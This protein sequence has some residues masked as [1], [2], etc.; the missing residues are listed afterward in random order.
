VATREPYPWGEKR[1][2]R[3]CDHARTE[4]VLLRPLGNVIV[5]MPPL[6]I[7]LDELDRIM[8]AVERGIVVASED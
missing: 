2:I 8:G 1:G 3:V 6:I 4:G 5:I 7:T